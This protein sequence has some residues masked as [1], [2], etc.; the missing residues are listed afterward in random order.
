M[1]A[2]GTVMLLGL[3]A[4]VAV[5][6]QAQTPEVP[7][8]VEV[9]GGL[10]VPVGAWAEDFGPGIGLGATL[11]YRVSPMFDLY[12]GYSWQSF[13]ADADWDETAE[14][15]DAGFS[16]GGRLTVQNMSS[17]RPW[18]SAGVLANRYT[19]KSTWPA[20]EYGDAGSVSESSDF[21]MGFEVGAGLSLPVGAQLSLTP[22]VGYRQHTPRRG[23][24]SWEEPLGYV[25]IL[26]GGRLSF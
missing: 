7:L 6:I 1:K 18:I 5:P 24:N 21:S 16:A 10:G 4:L 26:L 22:S 14:M 20:D 12:S 19:W 17:I 3:A 15:S 8:S 23:G 25:R 9:H 13:A 11:A 2:R